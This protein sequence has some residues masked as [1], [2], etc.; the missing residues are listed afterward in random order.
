[1]LAIIC[2]MQCEYDGIEKIFDKKEAYDLYGMKI[3]KGYIGRTNILLALSGIGCEKASYCSKILLEE[4]R[5]YTVLLIGL[6]GAVKQEI[7]LGDIVVSCNLNKI[8]NDRAAY[9]SSDMNL[10]Q[11][12]YKQLCRNKIPFSKRIQKKRNLV[13]PNIYL[14]DMITSNEPINNVKH[15][16]SIADEYDVLCVDME[17]YAIAEVVFEKKC[18][19]TSIRVI[20]DMANENAYLYMLRYQDDLCEYLGICLGNIIN[21]IEEGDYI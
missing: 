18:R 13:F 6:S 16:M 7:G 3:I 10:S 21:E 20:S 1:M 15:S 8:G 2:S 14:A 11:L 9:L 4:Y 19:F 5:I 12:V 17:S